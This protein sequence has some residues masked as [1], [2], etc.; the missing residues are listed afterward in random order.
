MA[1]GGSSQ[2]GMSK[3]GE[4][5]MA[6]VLYHLPAVLA[7]TAPIPNRYPH[8]CQTL[9]LSPCSPYRIEI[10]LVNTTC[11]PSLHP[12]KKIPVFSLVF[13][14]SGISFTEPSYRWKNKVIEKYI[15]PSL[16]YNIFIICWIFYHLLDWVWFSKVCASRIFWVYKL[17]ENNSCDHLLM[18][19]IYYIICL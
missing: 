13:P 19:I 3:V 6:G 4:E 14:F 5:F 2:H 10:Y 7:F 11:A 15:L 9:H 8:S 16:I 18:S 12:K 17:V 1:S